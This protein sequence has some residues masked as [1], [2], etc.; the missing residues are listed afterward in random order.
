MNSI[1]KLF[2]FALL[3]LGMA[4]ASTANA[5]SHGGNI[6]LQGH[7]TLLH[8]GQNGLDTVMLD[9]LRN[10][11]AKA[12]YSIAVIGSGAGFWRFSNG[13]TTATG[14]ESTTYF[15]TTSL[16]AG[17]QSWNDVF[18][19]D[20]MIVLSDTSCGGCDLTSTGSAALAGQSGRIASSFNAG[21]DIWGL[22]GARSGSYY[23]FLPA[24]VAATGPSIS[25]SS[26]FT[27]TAEG[28]AIGITSPMVNGFPTHNRFTSFA[29]AF[30]VLETRL[31]EDITI[32]LK[33][34]KITTGPGGGITTGPTGV[35]EASS[36]ALLGLGL[37][38][39]FS[40]RRK[41]QA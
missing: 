18:A 25:G 7:D 4:A 16:T 36:I 32:G 12:T 9:Y 3:S 14:Y 40:V 34:G 19:S 33:G 2:I 27:P 5:T 15:N 11:E 21:M 35:P 39:L 31:G 20:L 28:T 29:S 26:G 24:G 13:T 30:T 22:S 23:D 1:K 41:K 10:G 6:I 8:S 37:L 17:T 38:G